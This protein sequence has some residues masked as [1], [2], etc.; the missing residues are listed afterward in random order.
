MQCCVDAIL[1]VCRL[2]QRTGW[3]FGRIVYNLPS[4]HVLTL[5][6]VGLQ[7]LPRWKD[8]RCGWQH[9][10]H[11]LSLRLLPD[12]LRTERLHHVRHRHRLNWR[13][14]CLHKLFRWYRFWPR[15]QFRLHSVCIRLLPDCRGPE[16]LH[17]LCIWHLLC[18]RGQP[19]RDN[20]SRGVVVFI[21]FVWFHFSMQL[22]SRDVLCVQLLPVLLW[23]R[24]ILLWR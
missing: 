8:F 1:L 5:R 4:R 23:R 24:R 22:W 20:C 10:L 15:R 17:H 7:L 6:R 14:Q 13:G 3:I 9:R 16:R 19:L 21:C 2:L 18:G 11:S 12:V